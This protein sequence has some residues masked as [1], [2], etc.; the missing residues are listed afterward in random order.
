MA[1]ESY[2]LDPLRIPVGACGTPQV[3][4]IL[5][6]LI[7]RVTK[8]SS[9]FSVT[10]FSYTFKWLLKPVVNEFVWSQKWREILVNC[11]W[12]T[13]VKLL[14][15]GLL[16]RDLTWFA[17]LALDRQYLNMKITDNYRVFTFLQCHIYRWKKFKN[18]FLL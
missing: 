13:F 5:S 8:E 7:A 9:F 14:F 11:L 2:L 15:Y 10:L 4:N 6:S 1:G 12:W 3:Y 16:S 18:S 17:S